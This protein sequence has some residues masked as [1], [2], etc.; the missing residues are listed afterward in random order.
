MIH[1]L[2]PVKPGRS[3]GRMP[4][5]RDEPET[6]DPEYHIGKVLRRRKMALMGW[7]FHVLIRI[8]S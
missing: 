2:A 7:T 1:L 4:M 3:P 6:S 8:V 5:Y